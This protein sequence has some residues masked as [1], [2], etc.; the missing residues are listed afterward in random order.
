MKRISFLVIALIFLGAS[1][2]SSDTIDVQGIN[3]NFEFGKITLANAQTGTGAATNVYVLP[4]TMSKFTW[5][6]AYTG[7]TTS[8]TVY[9]QGSLDGSS[10]FTL[11]TSTSDEMRHVVNKPVRYVRSNINSINVTSITVTLIGMKY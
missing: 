11:D 4:S 7:G 5:V 6:A 2:V 10:W 8:S 1:L 3:N 9:L